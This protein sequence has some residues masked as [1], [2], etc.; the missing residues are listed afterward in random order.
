MQELVQG[1]KLMSGRPMYSRLS[2]ASSGN[3]PAGP[4]VKNPP[5]N[6]GDIGFDPRSRKI[7][8][9]E[10]RLSPGAPTTETH[11]PGAYAAQQEKPLQ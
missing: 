2:E 11:R 1:H 6:A 3:F 8:C 7:P 9:A 10:G 4:V 5:A